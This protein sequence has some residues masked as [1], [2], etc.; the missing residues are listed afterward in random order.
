MNME[1]SKELWIFLD[2]EET[3]ESMEMSGMD[4]KLN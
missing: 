1:K 2:H 3:T 4:G